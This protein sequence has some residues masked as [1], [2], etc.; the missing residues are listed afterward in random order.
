MEQTQHKQ[1]GWDHSFL[2]KEKRPVLGGIWT[3]DTVVCRQRA[4]P[5]E[6]PGQLSIGRVEIY[7]AMYHVW[8][9]QSSTN[10]P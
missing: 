4:L 7:N 3:H 1:I 6:P 5:A 8:E 9:S 2:S 10:Y